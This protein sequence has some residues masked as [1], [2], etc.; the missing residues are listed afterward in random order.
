MVGRFFIQQE[1]PVRL[2]PLIKQYIVSGTSI[3]SDQWPHLLKQ[4]FP[5]T[6]IIYDLQRTQLQA[7]VGRTTIV[8]A[9]RLSTLRNVDKILVVNGGKIAECGDILFH[10]NFRH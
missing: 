4:T 10:R 8:I 5:S 2:L 3:V 1:D 9:H 6:F 7:S